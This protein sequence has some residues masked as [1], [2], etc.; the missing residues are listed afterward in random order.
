MIPPELER[1]K[2]QLDDL[3]LAR[4]WSLDGY[5]FDESPF[6]GVH[7]VKHGDL[8]KLYWKE[9]AIFFVERKF[10][11]LSDAFREMLSAVT[12]LKRHEALQRSMLGLGIEAI[13]PDAE[14]VEMSNAVEDDEPSGE[15]TTAWDYFSSQLRLLAS[16]LPIMLIAM[17]LFA[18]VVSY[19]SSILGR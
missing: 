10:V 19:I 7:L 12:A 11:N 4:G 16:M 8:W 3:A 5:Y 14:D 18:I 9:P 2:I 13:P 1:L 15:S 17:L 6:E